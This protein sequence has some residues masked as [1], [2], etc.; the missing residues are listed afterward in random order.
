MSCLTMEIFV[1]NKEETMHARVAWC[2]SSDINPNNSNVSSMRT[3]SLSDV[4]A[5]STVPGTCAANIC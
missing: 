4:S 3:E 5:L 1:K 2:L